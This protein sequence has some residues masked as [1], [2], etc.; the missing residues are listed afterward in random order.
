L[1]GYVFPGLSNGCLRRGPNWEVELRKTWPYLKKHYQ[2]HEWKDIDINTSP[3][4]EPELDASEYKWML[5]ALAY[6]APALTSFSPLKANPMTQESEVSESNGQMQISTSKSYLG[7]KTL[8]VTVKTQK[9]W[10]K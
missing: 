3:S 2:C 6:F 1:K 7:T 4:C 10:N 9:E 8:S 5:Q